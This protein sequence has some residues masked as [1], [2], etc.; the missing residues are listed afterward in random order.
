MPAID[1]IRPRIAPMGRS[2]K[3]TGPAG[4]VHYRLSVHVRWV[5]DP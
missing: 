5:S 1:P 4:P 2:Y 3:R